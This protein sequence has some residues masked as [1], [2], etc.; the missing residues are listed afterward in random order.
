MRRLPAAAKA[1]SQAEGGCGEA[2]ALEIGGR[3]GEVLC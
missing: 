2:R 3:S 1:W